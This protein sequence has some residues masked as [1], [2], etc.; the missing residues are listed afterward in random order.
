VL[1]RCQGIF[2][3]RETFGTVACISTKE[4]NGQ[5]VERYDVV[6]AVVEVAEIS[7]RTLAT[8]R[9]KGDEMSRLALYLRA[10]LE[11]YRTSVYWQYVSFTCSMLID[12]A[13][14]QYSRAALMLLPILNVRE[15]WHIPEVLLIEREDPSKRYGLAG[16]QPGEMN[17]SPHP[18]TSG[19]CAGF[20][21]L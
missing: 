14:C 3:S 8:T 5:A 1:L 7:F 2:Y 10:R 15:R 17:R 18:Y 21:H 9:A 4:Q 20:E 19:K 16:E 6:S 12:A 11:T 13:A